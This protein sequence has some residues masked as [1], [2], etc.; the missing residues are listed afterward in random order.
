MLKG[1][2]AV[3]SMDPRQTSAHQEM[4]RTSMSQP[5]S[6]HRPGTRISLDIQMGRGSGRQSCVCQH[7]A[8][9]CCACQRCV[10]SRGRWDQGLEMIV[11]H[12]W[13]P[14]PHAPLIWSRNSTDRAGPLGRVL[15]S[16]PGCRN[17]SVEGFVSRI[18]SRTSD[19]QLQHCGR[20]H[21]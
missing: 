19:V 4:D 6:P 12:V 15:R 9:W 14:Y 13:L 3:S 8:C 21:V 1:D 5:R 18:R 20:L 7:C 16:W 17:T 2:G 10:Y 11:G